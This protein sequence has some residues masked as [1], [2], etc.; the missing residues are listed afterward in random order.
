MMPF[1]DLPKASIII[2]TYNRP[3][4]LTVAIASI[5]DQT[6]H[7]HEI[8]VVD[9]G[10]LTDPPL[11]ADAKR[12]GIQ[13]IYIR[14]SPENRGLTRSRNVGI[15]AATGD[16]LFFLD[17]DIKLFTD[18]LENSLACYHKHP[19]IDGMGGG[20]ILNKKPS[21]IQ[22]IWFCYEVLFCMT[23]FKKGYFLPSA[24]STNLGNPNLKTRF[25]PVEF[26]GGASFSFR[27]HVFETAR[28]S[29]EFAGYGLGEDKEFSYRISRSH[30]LY[31][32]P[33]AK[34][35]HFESPLMRYQKH[36][37]AKAKLLSKYRFLTRVNIK[38]RFKGVWFCYALIGFLL[39]RI[40][41]MLI[42]FDKS[43]VDRVKGTLAGFA[44]IL[45]KR[46]NP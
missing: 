11:Q 35:Y 25:G 32:N 18:F 34:L 43:E 21:L 42:S 45:K 15:E 17:D 3:K 30:T 33:D 31:A 7:P 9:D 8:I 16:I 22:K 24:F 28:F 37:R 38:N 20:E 10:A 4:D 19:H 44:T 27:R 40:I 39:K 2:A 23:G 29:E 5:L 1:S 6:V 46:R 14:K 12:K 36:D 41:I 13:Y 26:L